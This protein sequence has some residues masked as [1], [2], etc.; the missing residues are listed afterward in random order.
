MTR[1]ITRLWHAGNLP[2]RDG[3]YRADGA[4]RAV[5]ADTSARGG[6]AL[7]DPFNLDAWLL[8]NPEWCTCIDTTAELS[9][10]N[11]SGYLC[12]GEGSY[13]SEGFFARI[14]PDRTLAWVVYLEHSNPFFD[15][16]ID[17][18]NAT[19]RSTSGLSIT[20]SLTSREFGLR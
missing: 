8:A 10:P 20:V 3:L 11:G 1:T 13:G 15:A 16:A 4:T 6:L 2:I 12:C 7:L 9:L 19:V 14:S 5:R 18:S 17:G